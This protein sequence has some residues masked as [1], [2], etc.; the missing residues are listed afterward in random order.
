[1]Q[2]IG[3]IV[4]CLQ[5]GGAER[6]AADL[7]VYFD[8]H[9]YNVVFFTDLSFN[10]GYKYKGKLVN[11]TYHLD[12]S[13]KSA[14][15]KKVNELR[16]LKEQYNIDISISFMQFANYI[17]ILAKGRDKIILTTH[18]VN[19][20][21][22]KYEKSVFWADETFRDLYQ[23]ADLITFP[24]E[25]CRKDWIE[26]YGDKNNI[27][28]T[29]YNPVHAMAVKEN[30]N[31]QNIIIAIGRMHNIKRQWHIIR[32]FKAV[33]EE[34]PDC[35]LVI[36]GDGELRTK[37]ERLVLELEL[38]ND[39]EMI[40]NVT[41]VQDYLGK[42][43]IFTITSRLEAMPCSVLE[44]LSAGVPVVACDCP[45]GIREELNITCEHR[46]IIEPIRGECGTLVPD[47]KEFYTEQL[48]K[49]ELQLAD[50]IVY[51]LQNDEVRREMSKKACK[52]AEEFSIEHIGKLW[53]D[54][55]EEVNKKDVKITP[56]FELEKLK[57]LSIIETKED[58]T[59]K[60]YKDY[61]HLL[62][63]WMLLR[64]KNIKIKRYFEERGIKNI[65]IYGM[66]KIAHH[67]IVDLSDSD[68]NIVC[69]ID[70]KAFNINGDTPI[71][72]GDKEIPEADCIV[73]TPVYDEDSIRQSLDGK[74]K[75]PIVSLSEI[76]AGCIPG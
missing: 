62:E 13:G 38:K 28:R 65:I 39:V 42:A 54:A 26:H 68:I 20:E 18:S 50:E 9:G 12:G 70:R 58:S 2:N 5:G 21:Y 74:T 72:T 55:I 53:L 43:K 49:E 27:T 56:E 76:V 31:K 61:Y 47:I 33:K 64:E 59:V 67:L 51:L 73:I 4:N 15:E 34:Y 25:Y 60:M 37:L 45:G 3:I 40:G 29:I 17:N 35:K 14:I 30:E 41:N 7:S 46:N 24:S 52:R 32:A 6:C 57:S 11:F 16:N 23:Y 22:A 1:M 44:S 75:I 36:L 63:R 48:T 19:S 66:G 8:E 71:I 69:A 10:I